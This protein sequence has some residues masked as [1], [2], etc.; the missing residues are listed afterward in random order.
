MVDRRPIRWLLLTRREEDA[1]Q[2]GV[3]DGDLPALRGYMVRAT[4]NNNVHGT[5]ACFWLRH[6]GEWGEWPVAYEQLLYWGHTFEIHQ[7]LYAILDIRKG[8]FAT[9]YP[10]E[11]LHHIMTHRRLRAVF[12]ELDIPRPD[13]DDDFDS[14]ASEPGLDNTVA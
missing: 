4:R 11:A 9:E 10:A 2:C 12:A 3:L 1:F 6:D 7:P 8:Y 14:N 5:L 13:S